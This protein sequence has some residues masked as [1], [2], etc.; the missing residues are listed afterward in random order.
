MQRPARSAPGVGTAGSGRPSAQASLQRLH[1]AAADA[2]AVAAV[3]RTF[4][5]LD[6]AI[7]S[8]VHAHR[9]P[10]ALDHAAPVLL[11]LVADRA[12]GDRAGDRGD[13][14]PAAA[15]DLVADRGAD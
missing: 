4:A 6:R 3:V 1:V 13:L 14:A 8:V 11:D 10:V 15:A 5:L 12:T 9:D 7:A 2:H